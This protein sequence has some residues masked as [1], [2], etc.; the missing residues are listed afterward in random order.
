MSAHK[1]KRDR[2]TQL[3]TFLLALL[4]M[5]SVATGSMATEAHAPAAGGLFS[6]STVL[7]PSLNTT[8]PV[9]PSSGQLAIHAEGLKTQ[10]TKDA[11]SEDT[12][13]PASETS[14][15]SWWPVFWFALGS[16]LVGAI[17]FLSRRR[18]V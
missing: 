3:A 1:K 13:E 12:E 10:V 9:F 5:V 14:G 4:L 7:T 11:T 2:A 18:L 15:W 16:L 8:Q 17:V 6:T